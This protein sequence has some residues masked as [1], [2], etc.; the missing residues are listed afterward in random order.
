MIDIQPQLL[1]L[2]GLLNKRLFRIPQYQRS[3]SW[4]TRQRKALFDDILHA[5]QL[6]KDQQHFMATIV[7]LRRE[8]RMIGTDEHQV[9]EIVDGQQRITTLIMLLKAISKSVDSKESEEIKIKNEIED[10]LVKHDKISLLLLQTNHDISNYF[11]DYLRTGDR[12]A[13]ES[14][15]TSADHELLLA[16]EECEQFVK[17]WNERTFSLVDLM[18]LLKNR[19]NFVF[20]EISDESLVYT[21]FEVLNSRGLAVSWFDRLKSSLMAQIFEAKD[22][23]PEITNELHHLWSEIYRCIGLTIGMRTETLRFAASLKEGY[24]PSRLPSEEAAANI[25]RS[26]STGGV[27]QVIQTTNWL[28]SV[29]EALNI[30]L[31]NNRTRGVTRIIQA[32]LVAVAVHLRSDLTDEEKGGVLKKWEKVAFRMYGMSRL[33]ARFS[34]GE[35]IRLAWKIHNRKLTTK[36]IIED[37]E[38]IGSAYPIDKA[39]ENIQNMDC[40]NGWQDSLRYFFYRYEEYLAREAHQVFD[41][42]Q[43]NRIWLSNASDSIEHIL[44]QSSG[45][46]KIHRLG[47]LVLLPPKLNSKLR[48]LPPA[49]KPEEYRKTGMLIAIKA[50][51]DIDGNRWGPIRIKE[52]QTT[53]LDWARVEWA[54]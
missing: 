9:V 37:L 12:P 28:K 8:K 26:N 54:D 52:R 41:N 44:P 11:A 48:A 49:K 27:E 30:V 51:N 32:R 22:N 21:V 45:N 43:W 34:T 6:G 15:T 2:S 47:N 23:S 50:A 35:F 25:L 18:S 36:S 39:I 24:A 38:S 29:T 20:H 5:W 13:S 7:G 19:L 3:Y 40:Y 42:E 1:T 46:S 4:Q 16:M 33:D 14:A 53:L 10:L 31:G 17:L